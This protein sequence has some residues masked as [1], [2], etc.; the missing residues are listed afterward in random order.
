MFS[1]KNANP[2]NCASDVGSELLP[3]FDKF[4]INAGKGIVF[5]SRAKVLAEKV[6]KI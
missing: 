1:V 6:V 2:D 3:E 4:I 5:S